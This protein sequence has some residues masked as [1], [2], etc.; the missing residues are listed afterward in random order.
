VPDLVIDASIAVMLMVPNAAASSIDRNLLQDAD[1]L[2]SFLAPSIIATEVAAAITKLLRQRRISV[3]DANESFRNWREFLASDI[4]SL[5]P[6]NMLLSASFDLSVR[7]HHPLH[8]CLYMALAH[9]Q[10]AGLIT[11]DRVLAEKARLLGLR[12]EFVGA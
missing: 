2:S 5:I 10:K 11:A 9:R 7:L 3:A 8:D 12:T 1:P 6:A 4:L